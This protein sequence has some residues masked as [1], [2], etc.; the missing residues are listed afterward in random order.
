MA[1]LM[2]AFVVMLLLVHA[3]AVSTQGGVSTADRQLYTSILADIKKDVEDNYFDPTFKGLAFGAAV[4]A[5]SAKVAVAQSTAEAMDAITSLMFQFNDSHTLFYPPPRVNRIDYGW[6]MAAV[7]DEAR[8]VLVRK[9]SDAEAKG[10]R[11]GDRVLSLNR[12]RP[13]RANLWQ[14]AYY[15]NVVRPQSRQHVVVRKPDGTELAADVDSK[16]KQRRVVQTID[17]YDDILD[18]LDAVEDE[19]KEV[20]P[21]LLLWRIKQFRKAADT[22]ALVKKARKAGSVVIDLRGNPGGEIDALRRLVAMLFDREVHLMT[23]KGRSGSERLV[24]KPLEPRFGGR[25]VVLVDSESASS[26][27]C[28]ARIVQLEKRGT[29]IGDRTAGAVMAA[30]IFPHSFGSNRTTFYATSVTT[31][32]LWMADGS[33]LEHQGMTPDELLLPSQA[34]MAAGRDPVLARAI[35]LLGGSTTPAQAGQLFPRR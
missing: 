18:A 19:T 10:L 21:T 23:L 27:E 35:Q 20:S 14:I 34:D 3:A 22:A 25:L 17:L 1:R 13:S 28:F 12:F 16:E 33:S 4:D 32:D 11:P 9:D 24:A 30:R 7:G 8:V 15:Y 6:R 29:V 31:A 2:A 26:S 5:A